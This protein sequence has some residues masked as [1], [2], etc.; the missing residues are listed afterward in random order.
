MSKK[1]LVV[2]DVEVCRYMIAARS[3]E[4]GFEYKG[5]SNIDDAKQF[6]KEQSFDIIFLD[7]HIKQDK[8]VDHIKE[9]RDLAGSNTHIC[10]MSAIEKE[11]IMSELSTGLADSFIPKPADKQD[12]HEVLKL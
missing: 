5:A 11:T 7:Y 1:V 10:I 12:L 4:L 9:I 3:E 8:V 2:D 6:I